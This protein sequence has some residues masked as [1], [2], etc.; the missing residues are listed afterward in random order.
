MGIKKIEKITL[1]DIKFLDGAEEGTAIKRLKDK[2]NEI[3]TELNKH[4]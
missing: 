1:E 2:L 3:I 4:E